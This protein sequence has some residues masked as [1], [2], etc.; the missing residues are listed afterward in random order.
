MNIKKV[1]KIRTILKEKKLDSVLIEKQSNFSWLTGG[2][3]FVALASEGACGSILV[4]KDNVYLV[5]NSIESG[6]LLDEEAGSDLTPIYSLWYEGNS[7]A[8][9]LKYTGDKVATDTELSQE[10]FNVRTILDDDEIADYSYAGIKTGAAL[11]NAMKDLKKGMTEFELAG[12]ISARLWKLGF[13]PI[14][15]LIAF[16][17]RI[18]K[19]RHP[20]PTGN[21][22]E[23]LAMGVVCARYKGLVVSATRLVYIGSELPAD[24]RRRHDAVV[25]V[26]GLVINKTRP[27]ISE[28]ELFKIIKDG[29]TD[30]GYINEEHLHHQGGLTGYGAREKIASPS[31]NGIVAL[32]QAYAWNPSITGTKSEDTIIVKES[33]NKVIS[34]T[35]EWE[36]LTAHGYLRPDILL[37]K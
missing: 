17:W 29:Y 30:F 7:K 11:E 13:E 34:Y 21:K 28:S 22:L 15:L 27:G 3:G 9:M 8:D 14:V 4:T 37:I 20:L 18:Q 33:E 35:G 1:E 6:R 24:L 26:D 16:D 25:A 32:N 36:Y 19:Y 12:D 2:R 5:A 31:S 10:F 23:N